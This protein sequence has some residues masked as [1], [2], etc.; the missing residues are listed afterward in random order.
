[1][2]TDMLQISALVGALI[3]TG[4]GAESVIPVFGYMVG[5]LSLYPNPLELAMILSGGVF[6]ASIMKGFLHPL[7]GRGRK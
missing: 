4:A 6:I 3:L 2:I 1:M 5:V 7:T